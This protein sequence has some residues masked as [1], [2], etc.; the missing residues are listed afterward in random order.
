MTE[1]NIPVSE[2]IKLRIGRAF[3]DEFKKCVKKFYVKGKVT[4]EYTL[5][6][7]SVDNI[8]EFLKL[9]KKA[10]THVKIELKSIERSGNKYKVKLEKVFLDSASKLKRITRGNVLYD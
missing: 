1:L 7:N 9:E 10:S 2:E 3:I 6:F 5:Y 8:Y 4:R